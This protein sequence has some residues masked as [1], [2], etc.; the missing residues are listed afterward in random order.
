MNALGMPKR[1]FYN[2]QVKNCC[3][4]HVKVSFEPPELRVIKEIN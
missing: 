2:W 3:G 1:D 4:Y